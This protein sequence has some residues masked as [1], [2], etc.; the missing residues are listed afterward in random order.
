MHAGPPSTPMDEWHPR[1]LL[2]RPCL[3][4]R[5][6]G[7]W[8]CFPGCQRQEQ[9]RF[10]R[11]IRCGW[12]EECCRRTAVAK[13]L[14][15][16]CGRCLNAGPLC[17]SFFLA[18][19]STHPVGTNCPATAALMLI[20]DCVALPYGYAPL[21][22]PPLMCAASAAWCCRWRSSAQGARGGACAAPATSLAAPTSAATRACCWRTRRR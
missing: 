10:N 12:V 6:E 19:N 8:E 5:S 22:C 1:S 16:W 4:T 21:R 18:D 14:W 7:H 20:V 2:A 17:F 15:L 13:P 3:Q 9:C 11:F